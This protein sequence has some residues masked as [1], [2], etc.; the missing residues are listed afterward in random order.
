MTTTSVATPAPTTGAQ[1]GGTLDE[2]I[3]AGWRVIAAKE[4]ADLLTSVRSLVILIVLGLAGAG[5]LISVSSTI[6][7]VATQATGSH[8]VFLALFTLNPNTSLTT[9]QLP[10][11]VALVGFIGPLL[12]IALGFDSIN[13]ERSEGTL[14]RLVSQPIHRDDVINGKFVARL[15]VIAVILGAVVLIVCGVGIWR[16][17]IVPGLDDA[18]RIG[19]WYLLTVVYVG[20]WLSLATLASVLFRRAATAALVVLA[21]WLVLTFF[22][23]MIVDVLAGYLAPSGDLAWYGWREGI[24]QL[25]PQSLYSDVVAA[26]MD[27]AVRTLDVVSNALLQL[28]QRALPTILPFGQSL[29]VIWG[30][31][32]ILI[33]GTVLAFAL[34]YVAFMRQEVRA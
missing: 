19:T 30:Q 21:A 25:V 22:G 3:P 2:R 11:M 18:L 27:P 32:A 16:L 20:F 24:A 15:A 31:I 4:L 6:R 13:G 17:G 1:V 23:S 26:V 10:S 14:S 9:A 5:I 28:D 33:A 34:A 12:G 8:G 29:L 7:E